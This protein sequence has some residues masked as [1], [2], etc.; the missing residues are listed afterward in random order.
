M[1]K[2]ARAPGCYAMGTWE[3][4]IRESGGGY[5]DPISAKIHRVDW[6]KFH[7]DRKQALAASGGQIR[8]EPWLFSLLVPLLHALGLQGGS[9]A[10]KLRVLDIGGSFGQYRYRLEELC[11][12]LEIDWTVVETPSTVQEFADL[13]QPSM[14]WREAHDISDEPLAYDLTFICGTLPYLPEP[15]D[16]IRKY[17]KV[18]RFVVLGR[19][20]IV[21]QAQDHFF[22]Q[23]VSAQDRMPAFP[24]RFLS[25]PQLMQAAM[26]HANVKSFYVDAPS[27]ALR[28]ESVVPQYFTILLENR[29]TDTA[30]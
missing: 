22:L 12:K 29:S 10:S 20:P 16:A 19:V 18:S 2:V 13:E 7:E 1:T 17:T 15:F 23:Y 25:R 26:Q 14:R 4:A 6:T 24:G 3:Q 30:P 28:T 5:E 21:E 27:I 11:P 9:L 8:L